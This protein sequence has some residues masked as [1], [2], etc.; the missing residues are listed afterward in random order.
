MRCKT[1]LARLDDHVDGVLAVMESEAIRRHLDACAECNDAADAARYASATLAAWHDVEPPEDGYQKI[2]SRLEALPVEA[3]E[4][5]VSPAPKPVL[6]LPSMDVPRMRRVAT[7]G[8]AAAA[9]VLAAFVVAR[10]E[11]TRPMR[12][13]VSAPAATPVSMS[14]QGYRF[15]DGLLYQRP[16]RAPLRPFG[17]ES[18]LTEQL[19]GSPR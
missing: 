7:G 2:L 19:V 10:G 17:A 4:K 18:N 3:F 12:R 6:R 5:K 1:V 8:L 14:F 9:A 11:T 13:V 15:D 16:G